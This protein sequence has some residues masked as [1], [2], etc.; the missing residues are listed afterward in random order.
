MTCVS[1]G[2][3]AFKTEVIDAC[4]FHLE[5][6]H[7]LGVSQNITGLHILLANMTHAHVKS[8]AHLL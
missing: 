4:M 6:S 8:E 3:C 1:N 7:L 5:D 2:F